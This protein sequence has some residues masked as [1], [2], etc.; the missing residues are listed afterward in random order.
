M[1]ESFLVTYLKTII[2]DF[3]QFYS[4]VCI[5]LISV[6]LF[7][8]LHLGRYYYGSFIWRWKPGVEH[9][10]VVVAVELLIHVWF[11]RPQD[12]SPPGSSFHGIFLEYWSTLPH[13]SPGDP[14]NP[15]TE[16]KT[17]PSHRVEVDSLPLR[18]PG[19]L[20]NSYAST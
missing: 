17:L 15:G 14:P 19:S 12:Y 1:I 3:G 11:L 18:H 10:M 16:L 9:F 5:L 6:F 13:P 7:S 20:S 8:I 4:N 2:W